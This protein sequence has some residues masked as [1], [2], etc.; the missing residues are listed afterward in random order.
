M[1][2]IEIERICGPTPPNFQGLDSLP[3]NF[4]FENDPNFSAI[5]LYDFLGNAATV[6]SFTECAHYVQGG[7]EPSK[8]T[9]FDIVIPTIYFL[10]GLYTIYK[11]YKTNFFKNFKI[12]SFLKKS[13]YSLRKLEKTTKSVLKKSI[14]SSRNKE[15]TKKFLY[16]IFF[17]LQTYFSFDYIRTK[18][19]R[20][21]RFID[22]YITLTSNINFF[23]NLDFNA[24]EFLGGSY[25]VALT[26]GPISAV[27]SVIG[28]N[29]TN[30]IAI[31]RISNFFWIYI[32]QLIFIIILKKVY[33]KDVKFLF[34]INGLIFFL[35]PWWH[36]SL[37]SL[38]EIPSL[39]I[40]V[41]A[42]FLFPKL[43]YLSIFLF[44]LS[45]V[46]GKILNLLPFVGFYLVHMINEKKLKNI[47]KDVAVFFIPL[48]SWLLLAH[49]N[50]EKGNLIQYLNDQFL[51]I[52]NHRSS[53]SNLDGGSIIFNFTNSINASEFSTWNNYDKLRLTFVPI[54]FCII[55]YKN[56]DKVDLFFG[57][58]TCPLIFSISFSYLW[59]WLLND[60]KWIRYTQHFSVLLLIAIIYLIN[61]KL[62][63]TRLDLISIVAVFALFINNNKSLAVYFIL[64]SIIIVYKSEKNITYTFVQFLIVL[65]V[66][67]DISIPYFQKTTFGNLNDVI[68]ECKIQIMSNECKS[69]YLNE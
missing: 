42:I 24:G 7:W 13:I 54:L 63:E 11:I 51:F 55:L 45:I 44:S 43:R 66:L 69:K 20:I 22:E 47:I 40:F 1:D 68:E 27:G 29:F 39:I 50:Y 28:W 12:S 6:N 62:I 30:K 15:K 2:K 14:Y 67:I 58:V 48:T 34:Y 49:F 32:L 61:Y 38:G 19:V 3:T 25:S 65:I 64:I 36:G 23:K 21:P 53:G 4:I 10:I 8:I 5:N 26:S 35:I 18:T 56:K 46:Y 59:F 31:A 60:T 17:L 33:K 9:I 37:Y 41:N 16:S 52:T 57:K